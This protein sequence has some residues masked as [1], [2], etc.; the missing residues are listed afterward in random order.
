M[1]RISLLSVLIVLVGAT[2]AAAAT[3]SS[4]PTL[5]E[6]LARAKALHVGAEAKAVQRTFLRGARLDVGGDGAALGRTRLGG[7]PD[8]QRGAP[9]P[10]CG[11]RPLSFLAQVDLGELNAAVPGAT[12]GHGLLS[13]FADLREAANG[14]PPLEEFYGRLRAKACGVVIRH[15]SGPRARLH[16][17]A[18]TPRAVHTLRTTPVRLRPTLTVPN[19]S[20]IDT[21]LGHRLSRRQSDRWFAFAD[22]ANYGTLGRRPPITPLHQLLGW[23]TPIQDDPTYGCGG[24]GTTKVPSRRLLLQLDFDPALRFAIGDGGGLYLTITPRDLRA[25]RFNRLCAEFQEG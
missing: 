22:E 23:S 25:G 21:V 24:G 14:V 11:G 13:V 7:R 6:T 2:S 1:L 8:L 12:R 20:A 9:W 4:P 10:T 5:A 16:R 18:A 3:P 19:W 15:S 17:P